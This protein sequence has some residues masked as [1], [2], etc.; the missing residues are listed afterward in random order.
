MCDAPRWTNKAR[1]G[2]VTPVAEALL[3]EKCVF[4]NQEV[5]EDNAKRSIAA[6]RMLEPDFAVKVFLKNCPFKE[7]ACR[8]RTQGFFC[9]LTPYGMVFV[10]RG[11]RNQHFNTNVHVLVLVCVNQTGVLLYSARRTTTSSRNA[12]ISNKR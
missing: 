12:Y 8:K 10:V 7:A 3:E 2:D 5:V 4:T 9:R 1:H 11:Y 6:T